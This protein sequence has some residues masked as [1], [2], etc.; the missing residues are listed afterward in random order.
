LQQG[1]SCRQSC[2]AAADD[3][4]LDISPLIIGRAWSKAVAQSMPDVE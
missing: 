2:R 3:H 1:P 4:D